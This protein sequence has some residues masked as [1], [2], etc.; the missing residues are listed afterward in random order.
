[1]VLRRRNWELR[2]FVQDGS[3]CGIWAALHLCFY[4]PG[5]IGTAVAIEHGVSA[6][7]VEIFGIEEEAIHVE[8]AGTDGRKAK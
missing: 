3:C 2:P 5:E 1:M 7:S 4:A 8:E 6:S